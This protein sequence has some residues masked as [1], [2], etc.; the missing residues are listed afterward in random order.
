MTT[1][2][3]GSE[4]RSGGSVRPLTGEPDHG[5]AH[6]DVC[7]AVIAMVGHDLRQPLQII[8][9]AHDILARTICD[10][11]QREE[12]ARAE[13]ATSRLGWML[14]QLVDVVQLEEQSSEYRPEPVALRPI[15]RQLDL[16]FGEQARRRGIEFRVVPASAVVWSHPVLLTGIL[17]NLVRNAL[18]YT[19][20][21]GNVFVA[22]RSRGSEAHIEVRDNGVGIAPG[23]LVKIFD[24]FHR[25]DSS[26]ADGL[27]L[28]LFIVQRAAQF[29]GHRIE[30]RSALGR[31]SCF[32]VV[33]Q[34]PF[35]DPASCGRRSRRE[36]S[37]AML[38]A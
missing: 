25:A 4:I 35:F 32:T 38:P 15:H 8:A 23:E 22:C 19:P 11:E 17:R 26:R 10:T 30:V 12:L 13:S 5:T 9:N 2:D 37:N 6:R 27:G 3:I 31:G 20:P 7:A 29:L 14:N 21:G 28:G 24:A 18:D 34:R 36:P 1:L 16:E 33:G